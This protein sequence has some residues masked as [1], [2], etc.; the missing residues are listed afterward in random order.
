MVSLSAGPRKQQR[1]CGSTAT[2]L[3][4]AWLMKRVGTSPTAGKFLAGLVNLAIVL[5]KDNKKI[6]I[7]SFAHSQQ[8]CLCSAAL[9]L[10]LS[11][12][13]PL[14]LSFFSFCFTRSACNLPRALKY[15]LPSLVFFSEHLPYLLLCSSL[16]SSYLYLLLESQ[17]PP[18]PLKL[19]PPSSPSWK[20][21]VFFRTALNR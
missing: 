13:F 6:E 9:L 19:F 12:C 17:K 15:L 16:C 11:V 5:E 3:L 7:H 8:S 14:E 1:G 18:W 20:T 10:H 4:R 2:S 21:T